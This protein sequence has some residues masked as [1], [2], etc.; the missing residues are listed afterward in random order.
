MKAKEF[1]DNSETKERFSEMFRKFLPLAMHHIKIDRLPRMV[2]QGNINDDQQPTFGSYVRDE[3]TLYVVLSNRHPVDILRTVAH[4]LQHYKQDTEHKLNRNSGATGSPEENEAHAVAGM[5]MRHF[6]KRYPEYLNARPVIS[7]STGDTLTGPGEQLTPF[8]G[9]TI[10]DVKTED[11]SWSNL[12][13]GLSVDDKIFIFEEYYT[14]GNLTESTDKEKK[15][16]FVSLFD[17][18]DIPVK[19]KKYIVVPL[20][21]VSNRIVNLDTPSHMEFLGK[22]KD[23]L[24]FSDS[25]EQ[26]TYPSKVM[27]NLSIFNTFTFSTS[28]AYNKFRSNILLKFDAQLLNITSSDRDVSENFADGKNPQDKGDSAR[29]GIKKGISIAQLKNIRSSDSASARKKQLAHWQIN[30]RK[31]REK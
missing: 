8:R 16:Y 12:D 11:L 27:R 23:G 13:Q 6:N 21:L 19:G 4:E 5:V 25:L 15:D 22:S 7:E 24:V 2:F 26:K 30:M 3:N 31:G 28:T 1:I 17:L 29:Y 20:S 14:R 18:S 9:S 10:A